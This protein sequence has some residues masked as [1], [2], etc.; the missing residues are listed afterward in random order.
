[1]KC[2]CEKRET[3]ELKVEGDVGSDPIWCNKCGCNLDLE[4][5]PISDELK[6]ELMV[7]VL[8]YGEW[9]DWNTDKIK[10]S[11]IE[12]E[13]IHNELGKELTEKVKKE[14]GERYNIVFSPS[15]ITRSNQKE[16][17]LNSSTSFVTL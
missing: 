14:L 1:L 5:L 13:Q 3:F 2:F 6:E 16:V 10:T 4:N 17:L 15:M 8:K 9:I 11:W 7:C 12:L